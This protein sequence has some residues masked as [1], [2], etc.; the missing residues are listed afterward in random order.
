MFDHGLTDFATA[1][2][3]HGK[4]AFRHAGFSRSADHCGCH[5]FRNSRVGGMGDD[6]DRTTGGKRGSGVTTGNGVG[7]REITG[8]EN[9]NGAQ[10]TQNR[11]QVH[12]RDWLAVPVDRE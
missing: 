4:H 11:A 12:F 6:D 7:E 2:M 8:A 1:A 3:E 9:R 10:R 5:D